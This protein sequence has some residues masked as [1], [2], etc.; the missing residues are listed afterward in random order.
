MRHRHEWPGMAAMLI[1]FAAT[2]TRAD[3]PQAVIVWEWP[4][5]VGEATTLDL[6]LALL[7]R[8]PVMRRERWTT[9]AR[10]GRR[11]GG[12]TRPSRPTTAGRGLWTV[13]DDGGPWTVDRGPWTVDCGP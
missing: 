8:R 3:E 6:A 10:A 5:V 4:A 2:Q 1:V 7:P 13:T 11:I 9:L 12:R